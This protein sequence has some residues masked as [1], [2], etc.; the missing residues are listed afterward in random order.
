[1]LTLT[2][3][4][5]YQ[6]RHWLHRHNND[7]M[8]IFKTHWR[9]LTDFKGAIKWKKYSGCVNTTNS[10][11]LKIWKNPKNCVSSTGSF[12]L[13]VHRIYEFCDKK[14]SRKQ[15]SSQNLFCLFIW[16]PDRNLVTLFSTLALFVLSVDIFV[17]ERNVAYAS[18]Q[19]KPGDMWEK[20]KKNATQSCTP[21]PNTRL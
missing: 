17:P 8:D 3:Q 4:T 18:G 13:C 7:Y 2:T 15:K 16:S 21:T 12:W 14:S 10:N 1:M 11:H 6:H 19:F 5:R 20:G 9:L